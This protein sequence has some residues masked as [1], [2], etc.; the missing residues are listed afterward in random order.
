MQ[1]SMKDLPVS[2][3][4]KKGLR[5][6]AVQLT[7]RTYSIFNRRTGGTGM[8]QILPR[9]G[10]SRISR[11]DRVV[12]DS[13][14][15][16][17]LQ[18]GCNK[19]HRRPLKCFFEELMENGHG[20]FRGVKWFNGASEEYYH[21]V[22]CNTTGSVGVTHKDHSEVFRVA[23]VPIKMT[24]GGFNGVS[25]GTLQQQP[26]RWFCCL[27]V[28]VAPFNN[29]HQTASIVTFIWLISHYFCII[30]WIECIVH[31]ILVL[32]QNLEHDSTN[33]WWN[34]TWY[35]PV[36]TDSPDTEYSLRVLH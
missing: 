8:R 22:F 13:K 10:A 32:Y 36:L 7:P 11:A 19:G 28:P 9:Q 17:V 30:M 35:T 14:W 27:A 34:S 6:A 33:G 2:Q 1:K 16:D 12:Q 31:P 18:S 3:V 5:G 21:W 4:K 26:S 20:I 29:N 15:D 25:S 23:T 24:K